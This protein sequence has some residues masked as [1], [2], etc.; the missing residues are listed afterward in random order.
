MEQRSRP[1]RDVEQG[2]TS[3]RLEL[4]HGAAAFCWVRPILPAN[5]AGTQD[6]KETVQANKGHQ[7]RES[8]APFEMRSA[9]LHNFADELQG[10]KSG[11]FV[12]GLECQNARIT[13][14]N[15]DS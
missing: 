6:D 7:T 5:T 2:A 11:I 10:T 13:F 3:Y 8:T 12:R 1:G 4:R 9:V 14:E 15:R